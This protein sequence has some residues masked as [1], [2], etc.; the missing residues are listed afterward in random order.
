VVAKVGERVAVNKQGAQKFYGKRFNLRELNE[1]KIRKLYHT[2]ISKMS[3]ALENLR[4]SE[5][6]NRA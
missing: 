6:I 2:E 4:D 1:L 5:D 3:A